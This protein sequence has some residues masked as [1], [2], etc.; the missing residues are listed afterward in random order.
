MNTTNTG[1]LGIIGKR[2]RINVP[3]HAHNGLRATIMKAS[4]KNYSV[5]IDGVKA[6]QVVSQDSVKGYQGRRP[7]IN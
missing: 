3:G 7:K 1:A 2:V 4:K 5:R 6:L